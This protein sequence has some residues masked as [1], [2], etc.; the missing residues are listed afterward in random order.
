MGLPWPGRRRHPTLGDPGAGKQR[1]VGRHFL[2]LTVMIEDSFNS[3]WATG[4][5][6]H[7]QLLFTWSAV[8]L[9]SLNPFTITLS[10]LPPLFNIPSDYNIDSLAFLLAGYTSLIAILIF[11]R[12]TE[13]SLTISHSKAQ[14]L[15][16][17]KILATDYITVSIWITG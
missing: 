13:I 17:L 9:G 7:S 5:P 3:L 12:S 14:F 15:L 10:I 2:N 6:F 4:K 11:I 16:I 1:V 8:W